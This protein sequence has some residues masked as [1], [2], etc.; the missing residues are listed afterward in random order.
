MASDLYTEHYDMR[1][2]LA[3]KAQM[4]L[5]KTYS[6]IYNDSFY[7]EY[8]KGLKQLKNKKLI[9]KKDVYALVKNA[10]KNIE[11]DL[12]WYNED[13][14][15]EGIKTGVIKGKT[16]NY[17]IKDFLKLSLT[18]QGLQSLA[19]D[20]VIILYPHRNK[21]GSSGI[22]LNFYT[23]R[24]KSFHKNYGISIS[25][26]FKAAYEALMYIIERKGR[27]DT[28][29]VDFKNIDIDK[30]AL[31]MHSF[32]ITSMFYCGD[33]IKNN[34]NDFASI[35]KI[36]WELEFDDCIPYK[37]L[38]EKK[39]QFYKDVIQAVQSTIIQN[40]SQNEDHGAHMV[41]ACKNV[42]NLGETA[43]IRRREILTWVIQNQNSDNICVFLK[44][45]C[46][47]YAKTR[48]NL[49]LDEMQAILWKLEEGQKYIAELKKQEE[50]ENAE[51]QKFVSE[52]DKQFAPIKK[53][54]QTSVIQ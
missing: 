52:I 39:K 47:N 46:K 26:E 28:S 19:N 51:M 1:N 21:F 34:G 49:C 43:H 33:H 36:I 12:G 18:K 2:V 9:L 42:I 48:E 37:L 8:L 6:N 17:S 3:W 32:L 16:R 24:I 53:K 25:P 40:I 44:E 45:L 30:V 41:N 14:F 5:L 54:A 50:I 22:K 15:I 20:G 27:F 10:L 11:S 29:L 23:G 13:E 31:V 38:S 4:E 35:D 7:D